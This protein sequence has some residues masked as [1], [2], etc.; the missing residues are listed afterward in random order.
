MPT[1]SKS[2]KFAQPIDAV[3]IIV[4]TEPKGENAPPA[5]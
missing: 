2:S 5:E 1:K 3:V 4:E